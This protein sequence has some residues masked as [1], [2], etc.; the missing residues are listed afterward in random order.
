M[1]AF[2]LAYLAGVLTILTPCIWPVLPFVAA[3]ADRPFRQGGLPL[4]LGLA[5]AFAGVASLAA[6]AGGWAVTLNSHGRTIAL[7]IMVLFGA[8]MLFPS[9]AARLMAPAVTLGD[10][11]MQWNA[12]RS[13]SFGSSL[14]LGIATGFVWA[15]C[16]GPVLGL[17][18]T[19]AALNGPSLETSLLL[20]TYALGAASS[21]AAGMLLGRRIL[22]FFKPTL[23]WSDHMRRI[24]GVAVI[25]GALGIWCDLDTGLLV[26]LSSTA[27]NT[28]E[29]K[30][31]EAVSSAQAT[32]MAL[33]GPLAAVLGTTQW[34]NTP[35]LRAE[36]LRGKV[37]VVNFWTY[38]CINCLR[39]LPHVRGWAD[40]YKDQGLVVIGVHSP[41]FAF[42]KEA[43]KVQQALQDL[44]ITYP[45]AL[46][47]D[48][49]IWR[50]FGNR[51]WPAL[52]FIGPDGSI[53]HSVLGEGE[54]AKSERLIQKLL[55]EAGKPSAKD[56]APVV[57]TGAQAAPDLDNLGSGETYVGYAQASGFASSG[58]FVE[59][60]PHAYRNADDLRRN[61]WSLDGTW[62][63][64]S[65][66]ATLETAPG[67]IRHRFHAR[68]LHLVLAPPAP[69]ESMRFR[70]T[71]D[72]AAPGADHGADVD[73][74]GWG[75][76]KADRLYQLVR[77]SGEVRDRIF[78]IEFL[79]PGVRA[80]AFTFG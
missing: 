12:G 10:R 14:L 40:K 60:E 51:A 79:T 24:V 41:E 13:S 19:G 49:A 32:D 8:A 17:I 78:E 63:V 37:V 62:N 16:A 56:T 36:D 1:V 72:G 73:A 43:G 18:L 33:S 45:V 48:F 5:I 71:I 20:L 11:L 75:E 27:T 31:I 25:A 23:S 61:E 67:R 46:D 57:G 3:R 44:G 74:E 55:A 68:D 65:E 7:A 39:A 42:E 30:L 38:S 2:I 59:D 29:N 50:E 64:G 69:G 54:Y 47:N 34:F 15:P 53:R 70:V 21:L 77:Q 9:L 26:P 35:A 28:V 66:F 76:V 22:A 80:Y 4:L 6:F 58:G 52:Y